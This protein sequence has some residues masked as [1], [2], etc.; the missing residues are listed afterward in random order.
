SQHFGRPRQVDHL[1]S[2]VRDQPSVFFV[3]L[4][5]QSGSVSQAGVQRCNLSSLQSLN[6]STTE[7]PPGFKQFFCL[8]LPSGRD[9]RRLPPYPA[10]FCIFSRDGFHHVG[11]TGL[12]L[13]TSS[14]LPILASQCAGITG[15]SHCAQNWP[16]LNI[17]VSQGGGRP[18]QRDGEMAGCW[19]SQN[20]QPLY[21]LSSP[22]MGVH[23]LLCPKTI[24]TVTSK[25]TDYRSLLRS[26]I[27][28]KARRGDSRL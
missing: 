20:I 1:R 16:S 19:N 6:H 3:L 4:L 22:S 13:L 8:S 18:K 2:G 27:I 23:S 24:T 26:I 17:V 14:D 15:M 25:T 9:D 7:P 5:R 11:Q 10:N 21:Q 12:E 28:M